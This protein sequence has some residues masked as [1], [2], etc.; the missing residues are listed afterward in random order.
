MVIKGGM[1]YSVLSFSNLALLDLLSPPML[2]LEGYSQR[3][4]QTV[5]LGT[6][7]ISL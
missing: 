2:C 3:G 1:V 4:F 7:L 6:S 5:C